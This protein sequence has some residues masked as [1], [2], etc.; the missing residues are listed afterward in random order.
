MRRRLLVAGATGGLGTQIVRQLLDRGEKICLLV[1]DENRAAQMFGT[2]PEVIVGDTRNP[3]SLRTVVENVDAIICSTGS[4]SPGTDNSPEWVDYIGVSNLVQAA[5]QADVKH[6]VL[7][8]SI[9]VTK[10]DH[11]LNRFG[12]VLDWKLKGEHTLRDSGLAYTIIRPG[13][14]TDSPGGIK[15]LLIG[16][17]DKIT[18]M[19]TRADVARLCIAALDEPAARNVTLEV[20]ETE[21]EPQSNPTEYFDRL[22]PD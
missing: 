6:F 22:K 7:V 13:G 3:E 18:G 1:R 10:P 12:R 15:R 20:V 19:V 2:A 17:G 5:Q 11:P 9:A 21:G 4:R 8:S 16:Q 14:L